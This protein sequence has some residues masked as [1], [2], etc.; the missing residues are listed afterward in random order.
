MIADKILPAFYLLEV[1][2][3]AVNSIVAGNFGIER[4]ALGSKDFPSDLDAHTALDK[5]IKFILTGPIDASDVSETIEYNPEFFPSSTFTLSE[6]QKQEAADA[7]EYADQMDESLA[8]MNQVAVVITRMFDPVGDFV[9]IRKT[10]ESPTL[11]VQGKIAA[12]PQHYVRAKSIDKMIANTTPP[13]EHSKTEN[14]RIH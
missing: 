8:A 13:L 6:E 9:S 1:E 11:K 2:G 3:D 10:I 4:I 12:N 7:E 14:L 5:A